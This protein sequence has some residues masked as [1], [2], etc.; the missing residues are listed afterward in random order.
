[1]GIDA[2]KRVIHVSVGCSHAAV[3]VE[4][5]F[6]G[7]LLEPCHERLLTTYICRLGCLVHMHGIPYVRQLSVPHVWL[8]GE[9]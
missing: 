5:A 4:A 9:A 6:G 7:M 2:G 3:F 1:M 8:K